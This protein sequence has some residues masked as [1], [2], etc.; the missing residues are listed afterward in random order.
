MNFK[1]PAEAIQPWLEEQ[2]HWL[3]RHPELSF[4]EWETTKYIVAQ[5]EAM[6]I[7]VTTFPD[8]PGCIGHLKGSKP[9]KTVMLR[10]DID[11]L[12]TIENSGVEFSSENPGVMHA[13]GHDCHATNLLGAARL[14]K[15]VESELC[16]NVELL[17]QSG[18]EDFTGSRYYVH[19]GYLDDVDFVY[20]MHVW[21]NIPSGTLDISDGKRMAS[22]DNFVL[23]VH[24]VSA[25][26]SQPHNGKDAI[27]AACSIIMNLQTL[28]SRMNDPLNPLVVTVGKI[29]AG[30]QFNI[31]T[32]T[33][34]LEGT[35][36]GYSRAIREQVK[37]EFHK[38]VRTT[39]ES[40]G[41]TVDIEYRWLEDPISND[42]HKV[43][44]I[45]R[46]AAAKLVGAEN[47]RSLPAGLGSEDFGY[48]VNDRTG[49]RPVRNCAFGFVGCYDESCGAVWSIHSDKFK[50]NESILH[51]GA[52]QYAQFAYDYLEEM[53]KEAAK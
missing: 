19:N 50:I 35:I 51:I 47:V 49:T 2:R 14:L 1:K 44:A 27:V 21:P 28:V 37:E 43:N 22:C 16:G 42:D 5:L 4:Q 11:A 53:A 18:E 26:G 30:T 24:G 40:L 17:F 29:T 48:L 39:A 25:H 33:A 8:Y 9:G 31:I 7:P 23:T 32:D 38:L 3:H 12:P 15:A 10:A 52:A 46:A 13:C 34:V 6:D 20:G 41:C 45:A 36:R